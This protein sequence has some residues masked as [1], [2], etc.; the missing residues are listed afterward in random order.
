MAKITVINSKQYL[1]V[2][3]NKNIIISCS[4]CDIVHK[5]PLTICPRKNNNLICSE[6]NGFFK[7]IEQ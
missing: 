5:Y 7:E 6:F 3:L 4:E 2:K 1:Q